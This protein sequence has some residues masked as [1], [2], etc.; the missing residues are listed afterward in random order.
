[1]ENLK[2]KGASIDEDINKQVEAVYDELKSYIEGLICCDKI[3]HNILIREARFEHAMSTL[4]NL[5]WEKLRNKNEDTPPKKQ[6]KI[7]FYAVDQYSTCFIEDED[8]HATTNNPYGHIDE[9]RKKNN[10][11]YGLSTTEY[12]K[13]LEKDGYE[14]VIISHNGSY[15]SEVWSKSDGYVFKGKYKNLK[16]GDKYYDGYD[17]IHIKK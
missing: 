14:W 15:G 5:V 8:G 10:N 4:K 7:I 1:M 16:V 9:E 2:G 13:L 6:A 12:K 3:H 17:S 11:Y